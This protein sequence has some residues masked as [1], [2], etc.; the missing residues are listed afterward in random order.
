M[1]TAKLRESHVINGEQV[2]VTASVHHARG[3]KP[4]PQ[5]VLLALQGATGNKLTAI[6][7]SF[8]QV[9]EE[10]VRQIIQGVMSLSKSFMPFLSNE[11][12]EKNGFKSLSG[13]MFLDEQ[14][15]IWSVQEHEGGKV[16]VRSNTIDNPEELQGLL[17]K[18]SV[19]VPRGSDPS[20]FQAVA[21]SNSKVVAPEAGSF[22]TYTHEDNVHF[23]VVLSSV[24]K[25]EEESSYTGNVIV[26]DMESQSGE[27]LEIQDIQII[28]NAG[29]VEYEEPEELASEA[30]G[31]IGKTHIEKLVS[32]YQKVFG[33]RPDFFKQLS[34]RIRQHAYA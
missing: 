32:Y 30:T 28:A 20:Y 6:A 10:P 24:Y 16:C 18:C 9:S 15:Q 31:N 27:S 26:Y 17:S 13:N 23:G 1:F 25:T 2:A 29:Q 11:S 8:V 7:G 34:Q 21:S 14:E 22:I 5:E 19:T 4:N 12:M 33:H 3:E